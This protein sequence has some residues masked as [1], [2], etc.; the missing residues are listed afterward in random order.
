M[1]DAVWSKII[2]ISSVPKLDKS[3][4]G[5]ICPPTMTAQRIKQKDEQLV[6]KKEPI[7]EHKKKEAYIE[8][9][10][11]SLC[12]MCNAQLVAN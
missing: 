8:M 1:P 7:L 6:R 11:A 3:V 2:H 9:N 12:G 10:F 4:G 5:G